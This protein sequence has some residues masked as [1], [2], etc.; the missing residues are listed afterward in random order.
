M[1]K[2]VL[3]LV[4]VLLILTMILTACGGTSAPAKEE[5]IKID[6]KE[7]TIIPIWKWLLEE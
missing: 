5:T 3:S 6:N 4:S 7:I 1:R 2:K